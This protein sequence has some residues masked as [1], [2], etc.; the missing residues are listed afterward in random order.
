MVAGVL[1]PWAALAQQQNQSIDPM[2][3]FVP[4]RLDDA[5]VEMTEP[6]M[7]SDIPARYMFV[8]LLDG[9][10]APIGFRKPEGDG[11]FPTIV[12]AHM[13]GGLGLRWLREWTQYG[14]GTLEE[15]LDAG[16]AVVWMRY[17]AEVDTDFS[18]PL[19]VREFQGRQRYS[20]GPQEF[21]DAVEIIEFVK[22]L[23]EVDADRVGYMSVSHGGEMLMKIATQYHGLR[24]AIATEPASGGFLAVG[25]DPDPNAPDEPETLDVN[26]EQMQQ[27]AVTALRARLD[28]ATAMER[29]NA[30][31][32]PILIIGRDRDHNQETFRLNYEL[33]RD[34]GKAVEWLSYDHDEHGFSFVERNADGIYDPDP[35][36]REAVSASI[37]WFD[38]FMKSAQSRSP[39][40]EYGETA[41]GDWVYD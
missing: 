31:Q 32:T 28:E 26:T 11:P 41:G 9:V 33:L 39:V 20:R 19:T 30:I 34:A 27:E 23:P 25:P 2:W 24:A 17:R 4:E 18:V 29:I 3:L 13:N 1:V 6:V 16:Y 10:Y 7:G 5:Q 38:R 15:F 14:S 40:L 8:E 36:Q 35:I 12:F 21:E 37:A 22:S